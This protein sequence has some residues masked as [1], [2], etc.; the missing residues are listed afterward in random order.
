MRTALKNAADAIKQAQ[1]DPRAADKSKM[2]ELFLKKHISHHKT[3]PEIKPIKNFNGYNRID[4]K[5]SFKRDNFAFN[6]KYRMWSFNRFHRSNS[7]L[8]MEDELLIRFTVQ[9]TRPR[10]TRTCMV[11][12]SSAE[13]WMQPSKNADDSQSDE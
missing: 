11:V 4:S 5:I 1:A 3:V 12:V 6:F 9:K 7:D 13:I 10:V 8:V 2:L